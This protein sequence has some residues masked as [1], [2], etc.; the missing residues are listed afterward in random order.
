MTA[1]APAPATVISTFEAAVNTAKSYFSCWDKCFEQEYTPFDRAAAWRQYGSPGDLRIYTYFA[2][3][4]DGEIVELD[5]SASP[6][7]W[8][9]NGGIEVYDENP[10][11]QIEVPAGAVAFVTRE[12]RVDEHMVVLIVNPA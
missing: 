4:G 6:R 5:A 3:M 9:W 11:Y 10:S 8:S 12:E 1:T 2:V 7:G